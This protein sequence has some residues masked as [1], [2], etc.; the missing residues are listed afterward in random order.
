[1]AKSNRHR[2]GEALKLLGDGLAPFVGREMQAVHGDEWQ[3]I[4]VQM[5]GDRGGGK[6]KKIS[7]TDPAV[8][9]PLMWDQWNAVFKNTLGHGERSLVSELREARNR[10]A[11]M[12]HF[13]SCC[14]DALFASHTN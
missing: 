7:W 11:H 4:S 14:A 6:K 8:L 10:W 5:D 2:I 13:S 12:E 1:M 9:L 3:S